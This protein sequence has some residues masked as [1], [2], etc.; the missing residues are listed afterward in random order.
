MPG[1]AGRDMKTITDCL[2]LVDVREC[3]RDRT[4]TTK[5]LVVSNNVETNVVV[6]S[7]FVY[8]I[9]SLPLKVVSG[10]GAQIEQCTVLFEN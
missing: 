4:R 2:F 1:R 8:H 10:S 5:F 6:V 9:C 3:R 7:S